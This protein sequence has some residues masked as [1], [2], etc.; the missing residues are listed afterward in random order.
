MNSFFYH[1]R[2]W[3][4]IQLISCSFFFVIF[5]AHNSQVKSSEAFHFSSGDVMVSGSLRPLRLKL[6]RGDV[7]L[8]R[9]LEA[10]QWNSTST[11][12]S[13]GVALV[14]LNIGRYQGSFKGQP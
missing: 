13:H 7:L 1:L 12:Q 6:Q 14:E 4:D 5:L 11:W 3:D 8:W 10:M 2:F 9:E